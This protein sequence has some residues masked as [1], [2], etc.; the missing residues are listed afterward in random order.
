MRPSDDEIAWLVEQGLVTGDQATAIRDALRQRRRELKT[1]DEPAPSWRAR[2]DLLHVAYYGGALLVMGAMAF[3]VTVAWEAFGGLGLALIALAYAAAFVVIGRRM[4]RQHDLMIPGG[5]MITMAVAMMPLATYGIERHFGWWPGVDPGSY[6]GLHEWIKSGWLGMEVVTIAAAAAALRWFRFPFLTAPLAFC[7]WYLSMDATPMI[8]G[9]T[10]VW[11]AREWVSLGFGMAT[12]ALGGWLELKWHQDFGYWLYRFGLMAFWGG[13]LGVAF[14]GHYDQPVGTILRLLAGLLGIACAT[15]GSL[16][17]RMAFILSGTVAILT[18]AGHLLYRED[19][20]HYWASLA[21]GLV[22]VATA[23][24]LGQDGN[25]KQS[26]RHRDWGYDLAAA[27]ILWSAAGLTLMHAPEWRKALFVPAGMLSVL[28]AVILQQR[29]F[30]ALGS[31]GIL[32][33]IGHLATEIFQHSLLFPFILSGIGLGIIAV[34]VAYRK[35][36]RTWRQAL[37]RQLPAWLVARLPDVDQEL[38]LPL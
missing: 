13:F 18:Y 27:I 34:A 6:H 29:A 38:K 22:I 7:L 14:Q 32:V 8:A 37:I 31:V 28:G 35:H 16:H 21:Y 17:K 11:H 15:F 19:D 5:L 3:F 12:V 30:L 23:F 33:Y 26:R 24:A 10:L 20:P 25:L 4:W 36:Q 1:T 9:D 2:F